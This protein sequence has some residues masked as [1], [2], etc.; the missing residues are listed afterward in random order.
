LKGFVEKM[1]LGR[2]IDH[3]E[4]CAAIHF[5]SNASDK[6]NTLLVKVGISTADAEGAR[7]NR[8]SEI[9]DWNFEKV[10]TDAKAMWNKELSKIVVLES[11]K[12]IKLIFIRP[13]ITR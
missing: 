13:Y 12:E 5:E 8:E 6:S 7:K 9:P 11:R 4:L 1:I 10:K 3:D 2:T